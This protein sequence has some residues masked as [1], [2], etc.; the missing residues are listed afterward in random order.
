M[1]DDIMD[2]IRKQGKTLVLGIDD[3]EKAEIRLY[4]DKST[5]LQIIGK[6]LKDIE[7]ELGKEYPN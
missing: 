7:K 6:M 4:G 2:E 5:M 1:V 3:S